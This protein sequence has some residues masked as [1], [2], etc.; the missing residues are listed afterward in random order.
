VGFDVE[1]ALKS[2]HTAGL[3]LIN[4]RETAEFAGGR[5]TLQS[6]PGHGTRICVEI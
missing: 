4:M 2:R 1:K 5:F 3:G 6:V